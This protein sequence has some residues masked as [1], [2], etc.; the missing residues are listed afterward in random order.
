MKPIL[1][2]LEEVD[3]ENLMSYAKENHRSLASTCR[4]VLSKFFEENAKY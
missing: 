2:R 3:Y 1:I 4:Y